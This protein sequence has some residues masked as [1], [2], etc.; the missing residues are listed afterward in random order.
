MV[1]IYLYT[2]VLFFS[3]WVLDAL[4]FNRFLKK[5]KIVQ[6][7]ILYLLVGIMMTYI[8]TNFIWD[9]YNVIVGKI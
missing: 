7:R 5:N 6:A 4:D 8:V 1:K 3:I 9:F 2:I